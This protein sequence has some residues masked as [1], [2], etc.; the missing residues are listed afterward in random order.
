MDLNHIALWLAGIPA[1]SLLWR[2][3]RAPNRPL[4]WI[5]VAALVL[6]VEAVGWLAFR[7]H[8]GY[9]AAAVSFL[10]ITVPHWLHGAAGRAG[11]R[12]EFDR[13]RRLFALAAILHPWD[14]W[15]S[16]TRL[17]EAFS[18]AHAGNTDEAVALLQ[19]MAAGSAPSAALAH[20]QRLRL[21]GRW[22]ELKGWIERRGL[23]EL[24]RDPALLVLYLRATGELGEIDELAE[25]MMAHERT[26]AAA[27]VLDAATLYLFVFSGQPELTR[28][29]LTSTRQTYTPETRQFWLASAIKHTSDT[30]QARRLFGEL[31]SASDPELRGRAE[32]QFRALTDVATNRPASART[33][34]VVRHFARAFSERRH[35]LPNSPAHRAVRRVTLAFVI[36]NGL[37]YAWG[38]YPWFVDTR[39]SFGEFWAFYAPAILLGEWW[40]FAS[41]LFV[42]ANAIHLVMN[43]GGLWVLGPFVERAFGRFRFCLVYFFAGLSG[44]VVY[45]GIELFQL[46]A[47][48]HLVGAS[49]CIMGLL[50]A[51]AG[52][53]L[54]AWRK[55]GATIARQI[56]LRIL[57][58]VALQVAF[59][60]STPEVAGLAHAVG[61]LGGFFAALLLREGVSAQRSVEPL[62]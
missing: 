30:E 11:N 17:Y 49:G 54:R 62:A 31:R 41:Y 51:T 58:V 5:F 46:D 14:D 19:V 59:D 60:Y 22:R 47:P 20:A 9:A 29:A 8:A 6:L 55:Q 37:V 35:L 4:G 45:L 42:H 36:A 15:P 53:M 44:S 7:D 57:A 61:L 28:Q 2:S 25:F 43:L 23:S 50:G 52:V 38:S 16:A 34:Y 40:R 39:E 18:L 21:L 1:V 27:G 32:A 13:A 56:F 10:F 33:L 26:L 3:I 12:F 24:G 48:K